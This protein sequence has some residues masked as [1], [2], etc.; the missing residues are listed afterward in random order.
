LAVGY[1]LSLWFPHISIPYLGIINITFPKT[2][3]APLQ[4]LLSGGRMAPLGMGWQGYWG[5]TWQD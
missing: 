5:F 3:K 4:G 1:F 2:K